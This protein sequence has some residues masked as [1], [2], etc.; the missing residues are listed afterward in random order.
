MGNVKKETPIPF[1]SFKTETPLYIIVEEWWD[2]DAV[3]FEQVIDKW[4]AKY[5][6]T[7]Y[8]THIERVEDIIS[9]GS[10]KVLVTRTTYNPSCD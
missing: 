2:A 3:R 10:K 6:P 8:G 4:V 7:G 5:N 9:V 1:A